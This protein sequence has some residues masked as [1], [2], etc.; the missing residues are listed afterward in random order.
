MQTTLSHSESST[1]PRRTSRIA[2]AYHSTRLRG[3]RRARGLASQPQC[4]VDHLYVRKDFCFAFC[5]FSF[6]SFC[7]KPLALYS[8]ISSFT[9]AHLPFWTP[10]FLHPRYLYIYRSALD[11]ISVNLSLFRALHPLAIVAARLCDRLSLETPP[12]H[13]VFTLP[14]LRFS[15]LYFPLVGL[16]ICQEAFAPLPP[17]LPLRS[18][19]LPPDCSTTNQDTVLSLVRNLLLLRSNFV[20]VKYLKIDRDSITLY[21]QCSRLS[22]RHHCQTRQT[23]RSQ[24]PKSPILLLECRWGWKQGHH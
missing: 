19:T 13:L 8:A 4:T 22:Q 7:F 2:K 15:C 11:H 16:W 5:T 10:H 24:H 9:L 6:I 21:P 18:H 14:P 1:P 23:Y 12:S 3:A 17:P 20:Q